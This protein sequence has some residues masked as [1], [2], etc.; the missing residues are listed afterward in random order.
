MINNIY[1]I[2]NI[3]SKR[4]EQIYEF[5]TDNY[6]R[7]RIIEIAKENPRYIRLDESELYRIG[8]MEIE[9]GRL[10]SMEKPLLV[11]IETGAAT[12]IE[13]IEKELTNQEKQ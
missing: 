2:Y 9:T 4:F 13:N 8:S 11:E 6:A 5:P 1:S 7:Q 12:P 10:V 3:L